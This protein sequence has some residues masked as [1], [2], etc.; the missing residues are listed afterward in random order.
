MK[1][2]INPTIKAHLIRGAFYMLL[3][4]AV[5]AIP[6]ALAQRNSSKR[7]LAR[8]NAAGTKF[9]PAKARPGMQF[10][11]AGRHAPPYDG[12]TFPYSSVRTEGSATK[13][14]LPNLPRTSHEPLNSSG[15]LAAHLLIPPARPKAPQVVLYDQ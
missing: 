4:L 11:T 12:P 14:A 1:K 5:C 6:F 2:Q 15:P 13:V 3:L 7:S 10:S 8:P 9:V